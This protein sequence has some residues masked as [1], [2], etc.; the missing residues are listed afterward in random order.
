MDKIINGSIND[1]SIF[2]EPENDGLYIVGLQE[3]ERNPFEDYDVRAMAAYA[4]EH[5]IKI[6][7]QEETDRFKKNRR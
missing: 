5:G 3:G 7:T 2:D 1:R 4:R 6:L